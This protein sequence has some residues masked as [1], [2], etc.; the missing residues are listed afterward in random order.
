MTHRLI[1]TQYEMQAMLK[2]RREEDPVFKKTFTD[3]EDAQ[4]EIR[5]LKQQ[6]DKA[7][8]ENLDLQRAN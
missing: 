6:L 2:E 7:N 8:E 3:L 1:K 5:E 4:Y